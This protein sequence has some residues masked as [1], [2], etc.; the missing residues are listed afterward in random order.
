[1]SEAM[2]AQVPQI[3]AIDQ[4]VAGLE[5]SFALLREIQQQYQ[6][7]ITAQIA[8]IVQQ[9]AEKGRTQ[10]QTVF[11]GLGVLIII[12][13]TL[14]SLRLAPVENGLTRNTSDITE[15]RSE[16]VP[17]GEHLEKWRSNDERFAEVERQIASSRDAA[18]SEQRHTQSDLDEVKKGIGG[19]YGLRD[20]LLDLKTRLDRVEH[21][22]EGGKP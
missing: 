2:S 10:W 11:S 16:V 19:T 21:R 20:A 13:G 7:S 14:G 3:A 8:S 22:E 6:T 1:M 15:L 18:L 4:R 5:Q 17:R 12:M 9:I